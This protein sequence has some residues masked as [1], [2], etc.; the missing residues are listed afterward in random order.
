MAV[1]G[2]EL[3]AWADDTLSV[4]VLEES[5][6][7]SVGRANDPRDLFPVVRGLKLLLGQSQRQLGRGEA[8]A[9]ACADVVTEH[10]ADAS[11]VECKA[12]KGAV[13][14]RGLWVDH[15]AEGFSDAQFLGADVALG[16]ANYKSLHGPVG[17][18]LQ[19]LHRRALVVSDLWANDLFCAMVDTLDHVAIEHE[20]VW[21][22]IHYLVYGAQ[23]SNPAL[24][25]PYLH[26]ILGDRDV[27][28]ID[29][30]RGQKALAASSVN[31]G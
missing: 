9:H 1:V 16:P 8:A 28:Q 18:W 17:Q 24:P 14:R 31:V 7:M 2:K 12:L 21:V 15:S 22:A 10:T 25:K 30:F 26:G 6:P 20:C 11:D 3:P 13:A 19:D 27:L 4:V 23:G 29:E 5:P